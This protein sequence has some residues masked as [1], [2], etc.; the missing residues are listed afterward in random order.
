M[1]KH[2]SGKEIWTSYRKE[3]DGD[4]VGRKCGVEKWKY[5]VMNEK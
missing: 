2:L 5:D 4:V 1:Y 3:A